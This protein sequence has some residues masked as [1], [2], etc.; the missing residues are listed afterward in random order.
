LFACRRVADGFRYFYPEPIYA[1]PLYVPPAVV[2]EQ[3]PPVPAG[4]PPMPCR[5]HCDDP[6]GYYPCVASCAAP[7]RPVPATPPAAPVAPPT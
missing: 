3:A 4:M 2:V 5:Y 6:Q 1:D 7:W